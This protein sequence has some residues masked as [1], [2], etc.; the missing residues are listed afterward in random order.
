[1]KWKTYNRIGDVVYGSIIRYNNKYYLYITTQEMFA[2][3]NAWGNAC[4]SCKEIGL[5]IYDPVDVLVFSD[6]FNKTNPTALLMTISKWLH[7]NGNK[8]PTEV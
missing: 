4:I 8:L 1:M 3:N 5:S 2:F 7:D 6:E